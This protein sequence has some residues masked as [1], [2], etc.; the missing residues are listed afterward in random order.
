MNFK[1]EMFNLL[2]EKKEELAAFKNKEIN[3]VTLD[4]KTLGYGAADGGV[5]GVADS[6][7]PFE[8]RVADIKFDPHFKRRMR[9]YIPVGASS[10]DSV[11]YNVQSDSGVQADP[12][13]HGAAFAN[14]GA[15]LDNKV[16]YYG[17]LWCIY[18]TS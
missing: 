12:K 18:Q 5:T 1:S 17:N 7:V 14:Y 8:D 15:T 4:L 3:G 6:H 2:N 10:G 13:A 11:R 16:C 9:N